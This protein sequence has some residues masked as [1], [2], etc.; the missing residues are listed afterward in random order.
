MSER[1][2]HQGRSLLAS[3]RAGVAGM[4]AALLMLGAANTAYS[5]PADAPVLTA[6]GRVVD[7]VTGEQLISANVVRGD[8]AGVQ[9]DRLGRFELEVATG[10][11]ITVSHIGYATSTVLPSGR[12]ITVRLE[13]R[14]LTVPQ[15]RVTGGLLAG[16]LDDV[17]A[18]VTVLQAAEIA[19]SG[20]PHLQDLVQSVP[21]LNWAGSTSRPRYFQVRGIGERS[22]YAGEGPPNFS[23]GL[24]MDDVD[25][26][27]MG[28]AA[29]LHD[30]AQ[31]EVFKG[32][33][34]SSFGPNAMAGLINMQSAAPVS[35]P[36]Q[37][38]SVSAGNDDMLRYSGSINF[39]VSEEV[40]ARLSFHDA[41]ADG[42]RDNVFLGRDDTNRRR[43]TFARAKVLYAAADGT[44][45][46][47]TLFRS[48]ADNR[49][50]AWAADNNENLVTYSDN[51]GQDRQLTKA[52][53]LR[54]ELP[55]ASLDGRLTT[56][57][58][59]SDTDLEHSFDGDWGNDAYWSGDPF[60]FDPEVEG[61]RYD[62]FDRIRRERRTLT[63]EVRLLKSGL[64]Q[65]GDELIVG[66]YLKDLRETD[67]AAGYLFGGDATD[68][69]S[70]FDLDDAALY[71]Q[72]GFDLSE[73]LRASAN[74]RVDRH[75]IS[76]TGVTDAGTPPIAFDVTDWLAGGRLA[77]QYDLDRRRTLYASASQG[78]R[79]GGVNQHPR[80]AAHNRPYDPE[81]AVNFELG[82]RSST[83][84]STSSLTLFHTLRR[85]QQV[86]LSSQQDAGDPNSFVYFIANASRGRNSGLEWE[87]TYR[88]VA[89][90]RLFGSLAY[91]A[92]HVE[93]YTFQTA[94][95][96]SLTRGDRAAAHAPAYSLRVGGEYRSRH[97]LFG[98][99]ELTA[100][101]D[102][103]F[104][105][106]HDQRSE[107]YRLVHGA[108]GYEW[109][110]WTVNLWGRNLLD[111]R[112][113][114]RG[115]YFGLEPPDFEDTLYKSYGDP[116]QLGVTLSARF[117]GE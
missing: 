12:F 28:T 109:R 54:G 39:P 21:N 49:F 32:P 97:G 45:W 57:T 43:E 11:S 86:S 62:F 105:D 3:T 9:T 79:P 104:S 77:L 25:L 50:D 23:V 102:F 40:A 61:Y 94:T 59:Y 68:L 100:M 96:A 22:H 71:G 36:L 42:F 65:G 107:A 82:L 60:G 84:R 4:I 38:L 117:D 24:V 75:V 44:S 29:M 16:V 14:A 37:A 74:L 83:R 53:S 112:Y 48:H 34:S 76:Y 72:Y 98:R 27:G 15:V 5:Q 108:L 56:I 101:D 88:P 41:R 93:A 7:A 20:A 81:Y 1:H 35:T 31:L 116:R 85:V 73:K 90:L 6:G 103:Y 8:G 63:Q 52:G 114:V 99:L 51:P 30:V 89:R 46:T 95:G 2:S 70:R 10:D 91:L 115:F 78:Y 13:P 110:Q 80:L 87:Q 47:A 58:S 67:D 26:S 66:V 111:E 64:R 92:T 113:A 69:D 17:P 55:L 18:S 33:Q 19:S 106:G